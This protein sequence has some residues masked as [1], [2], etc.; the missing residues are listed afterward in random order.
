M[1]EGRVAEVV[2]QGYGLG[3]FR[4]DVIA[5]LLWGGFLRLV[6]VHHTTFFVNS[7][8]HY[9]GKPTYNGLNGT[10]VMFGEGDAFAKSANRFCGTCD[11]SVRES[12]VRNNSRVKRWP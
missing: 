9:V 10:C 6:V 7:L 4:G 12:S 8:A 1:S 5:G 2:R 3:D 11:P